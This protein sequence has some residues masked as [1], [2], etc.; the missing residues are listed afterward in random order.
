MSAGGALEARSEQFDECARVD[1]RMEYSLA[2]RM[3]EDK[4]FPVLRE[5]GIGA[6]FFGVLS[7]GLAQ[8]E[9]LLP[10]GAVKGSRYPEAQMA[11]LDSE[12]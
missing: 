3:P 2:T 9:R 1:V 11:Q 4:I 6:T 10:K 12:R 5:L 7:R 8:L